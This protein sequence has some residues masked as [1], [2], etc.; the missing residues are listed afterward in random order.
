V[1]TNPSSD[2]LAA[3]LADPVLVDDDEQFMV[4]RVVKKPDAEKAALAAI[5]EGML[6]PADIDA[7]RVDDM[8]LAWVPIWRFDIS[9]RGFHLGLSR[10]SGVT[11]PTGGTRHRD[12]VRL[13]L[14]RRLLAIDPTGKLVI[15]TAHMVPCA[16]KRPPG[17][18]LVQPDVDR[19][20]AEQQ[21]KE[22]MRRTVE[23]GNA[24]FSK[25][26]TDVR[27]VALVQY[28]LMIVRYRYEGEAKADLAP[29]DCHVAI[30]G[31]TGK[32]VSEKHPSA[33][34]SIGT[35]LKKWFS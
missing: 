3:Q 2:R 30:S 28:P 11:L 1:K 18:E 22:A 10:G 27:S 19:D 17:G 34:R 25:V 4:E 7:S 8:M 13:V 12:E 29:E 35:K 9:V 15:E 14:A 20:D 21:A 26:E 31:R 16:G 6:R 32:I 33:L 5:K 24:L 23:P